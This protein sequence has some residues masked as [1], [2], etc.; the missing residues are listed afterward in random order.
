MDKISYMYRGDPEYFS[1]LY[2]TYRDKR[3]NVCLQRCVLV[4]D[5]IWGRKERGGE[6]R[7]RREKGEGRG[8]EGDKGRGEGRAEEGRAGGEEGEGRA[9]EGRGGR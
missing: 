8:G 5:D 7:G 2:I 1:G 6:D 3:F 4:L 9:G